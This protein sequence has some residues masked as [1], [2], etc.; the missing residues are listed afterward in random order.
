MKLDPL[1][2]TPDDAIKEAYRRFEDA[3][4]EDQE[5]WGN[6][7]RGLYKAKEILIEEGLYDPIKGKFTDKAWNIRINNVIQK[8]Q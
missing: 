4:V 7:L 6:M 5:D 2:F 1:S 8:D 3:K